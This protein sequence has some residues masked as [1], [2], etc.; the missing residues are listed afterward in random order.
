MTPAPTTTRRAGTC[1]SVSAPVEV[2][3]RVSSISTPLSGDD[4]EPVA[5]TMALASTIWLVPS[6][7]VT[8]ILPGARI[9]PVPM[10]ASILFFLKR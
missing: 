6:R 1:A 3:T 10:K 5:M 4:S 7:A 8:L 9:E 2:T